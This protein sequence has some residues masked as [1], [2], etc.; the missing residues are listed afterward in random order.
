M[1]ILSLNLLSNISV[2]LVSLIA[3]IHLQ[4]Y[5]SR[6]GDRTLAVTFGCIMGGAATATMLTP[7]ELRPGILI[8]LRS[9][10]LATAG[11]FG[12]PVA[13]AVAVIVPA[14]YRI[15]LGGAGAPAGV[16]TILLAAGIGTLS[17]IAV[18]GR[19]V[20]LRHVLA[21][22]AAAAAGTT[23]GFLALPR[24][25]W[26]LA[27]STVAPLTAVLT[28][29]ATAVAGLLMIQEARRRELARSNLIY[30]A[31]VQALPDCLN[32]KDLAGR[33]VVANPATAALMRADSAESL[34]GRTDF[35]FYPEETARRF[36]KEELDAIHTGQVTTP[37]QHVVHADGSEDW[38]STLKVPLR[39]AHGRLTG[40]ITHNRNITERKRLEQELADSRELL[41][42]ALANMADAVALFDR[43]R[44]LAFCNEQYRRLFARTADVRRP[45]APLRLIL[46]VSLQRGEQVG[47]APDE[48]EAW[49]EKVHA[50]LN[51]GSDRITQLAGGR[52]VHVRTRPIQDG[53]ALVILTDFTDE[54]NTQD[55]LLERHRQLETLAS[56]DWLTSLKNRR[57]FDETLAREVGQ[58][59]ELTTALSLMLIDV[60]HFKS[61]ND[62]YGHQAGDRCLRDISACLRGSLQRP[63]D[64]AARYGGEELAAILP[65]TTMAGA[66]QI[67]EMFRRAVRDSAIPHEGSATGFVTVSIGLATAVR[68]GA[69]ISAPELVARA[70]AALYAAKA[71]GRDHIHTW[72]PDGDGQGQLFRLA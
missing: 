19:V 48:A 44:R 22:S 17:H 10:A 26:P 46:Q 3:W 30:R 40:L 37:E 24:A 36:H 2:F 16:L 53:R 7:F 23:I 14:T 29:A 52:W 31:I 57:A 6:Y 70:D 50:S 63:G 68:G 1:A 12:G 67:A 35:D 49:I 28:F 64:T 54:K 38:L 21:V 39:D 8:D 41:T 65:N 4:D 45:G 9:S 34:I 15:A 13:G 32:V 5:L 47:V 61:F 25:V 62:I 71:A 33:F 51:A 72:Q 55:M 43:D 11:F 42:V 58:G 60:D 18:R 66:A 69:P 59:R 56:T 20:R 27:F